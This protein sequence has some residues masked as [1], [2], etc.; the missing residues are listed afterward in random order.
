MKTTSTLTKTFTAHLQ[1]I[2]CASAL[3]CLFSTHSLFAQ[4]FPEKSISRELPGVEFITITMDPVHWNLTHV[5]ANYRVALDYFPDL[6]SIKG[7][8]PHRLDVR[9][10]PHFNEM[11]DA[12]LADGVHLITSSSFRSVGHQDTLLNNSAL[13]SMRQDSLLTIEEALLKASHS[14]MFPGGSEHNLGLCVDF[15]TEREEGEVRGFDSTPQYAWLMVHAA[16]Y[17]FTLRYPEDKTEITGIIFEPWHWRYVG[18]E[19]A[20]D[21]KEKEICLE[22][23]LGKRYLTPQDIQELKDQGISVEDYLRKQL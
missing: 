19:V 11:Y 1:A 6:D 2:I 4:N 7:P 21:L 15:Y 12:A 5:N 18:V 22:E 10:A 20:K 9:V 16:D 23:Y 8:R 17:G 3:L 14:T 13:R